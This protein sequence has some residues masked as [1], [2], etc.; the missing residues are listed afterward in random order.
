MI[1]IFFPPPPKNVFNIFGR[2]QER[3]QASANLQSLEITIIDRDE[4]KRSYEKLEEITSR[5]ICAG[6]PGFDSCKGDSGGPVVINKTLVGVISWGKGC[7]R[8][9]Y[10]GVYTNIANE[11]IRDFIRKITGI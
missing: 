11:E 5:M 6:S 2:F 4:C 3:G 10:P 8:E 9:G 1:T 7:G